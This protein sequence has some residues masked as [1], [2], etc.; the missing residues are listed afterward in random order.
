MTSRRRRNSATMRS[1]GA[2]G[3][4]RAAIPASWVKEAAQEF[5]FTISCAIRAANSLDITPNPNRHPV[6]AYAFENPSKRIV[7]SFI[8]GT[9]AM[10]WWLPS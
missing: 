2:R 5:E 3:P 9:L 6:M 10:L 1:M 8:P 7:R 4:R